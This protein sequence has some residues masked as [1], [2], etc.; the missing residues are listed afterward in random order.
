VSFCVAVLFLVPLFLDIFSGSDIFDRA[1]G[2]NDPSMSQLLQDITVLGL[3]Q[4]I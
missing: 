1:F 4:E 2:Q 3:T